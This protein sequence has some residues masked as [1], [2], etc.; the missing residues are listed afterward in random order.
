MNAVKLQRLKNRTEDI[1]ALENFEEFE[2][3]KLTDYQYR[4]NGFMDLYPTN[5]RFFNILTKENGSY[6]WDKVVE[7]MFE[8]ME[9]MNVRSPIKHYRKI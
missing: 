7:F 4:V 6:E 2:V 9:K 8:Q 1:L 3:V 5:L